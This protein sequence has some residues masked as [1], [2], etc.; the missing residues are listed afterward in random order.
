MA[1]YGRQ[2]NAVFTGIPE[3]V[4]DDKLENIVLKISNVINVNF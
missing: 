1:Q 3:I 4:K 2:N